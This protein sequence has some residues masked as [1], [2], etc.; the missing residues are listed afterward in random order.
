MNGLMEH[1][2]P[3]EEKYALCYP[4]ASTPSIFSSRTQVPAIKGKYSHQLFGASSL[5]AELF[6]AMYSQKG[7]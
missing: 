2:R 6:I 4:Q 7:G 3:Q 5:I 1:A